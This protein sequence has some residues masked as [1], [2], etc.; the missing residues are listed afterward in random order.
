MYQDKALE[1]N[2]ESSDAVAQESN[3]ESDQQED[4]PEKIQDEIPVIDPVGA[5]ASS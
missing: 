1:A 3:E 2:T 5:S 4:E